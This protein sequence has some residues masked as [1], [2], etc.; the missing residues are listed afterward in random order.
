MIKNQHKL[1]SASSFGCLGYNE[2]STKERKA[3]S[4]GI[5]INFQKLNFRYIYYKDFIIGIRE[6]L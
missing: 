1:L 6:T 4:K 3:N 2:A 5:S